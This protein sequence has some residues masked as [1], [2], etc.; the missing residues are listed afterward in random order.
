MM[1]TNDVVTSIHDLP[2][3]L[4]NNRAYWCGWVSPDG[5]DDD[6]PIFRTGVPHPLLNGVLR[7]RNRPIDETVA[8][9]GRRL[10]GTPWLW[11]VG[12]DSDPG[13]A[14]A[15]AAQ[16]G[17]QVSTMPVMAVDLDQ[18]AEL[19]GPPGLVVD[20]IDDSE[21][22]A[23]VA[24]YGPSLGVPDDAVATVTEL[25]ID[26]PAGRAEL[27]RFVAR[28]DGRVVGTAATLI[29]N[30]VAGIYVVSTVAEQ[31]G[32]GIGTAVTAAALR[33]GRER[34][35]RVGTLQA[36]SAGEPVY[37]RMGFETIDHYRLFSL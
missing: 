24:V 14:D 32:R 26:R 22:P 28:L 16:G 21:I 29:S 18:V 3:Q 30:G 9:A 6:L 33:A 17:R 35:L 15:L 4:A 19:P 13:I 20:Q 36:S 37:R 7:V 12:A 27:L 5:A 2:A 11:W 10:A 8:Q 25:E 31:R 1:P 23:F 34:G